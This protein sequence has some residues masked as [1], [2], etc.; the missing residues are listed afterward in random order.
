MATSTRGSSTA[1]LPCGDERL[2]SIDVD[3]TDFPHL[4]ATRVLEFRAVEVVGGQ[5]SGTS[6]AEFLMRV[7]RSTSPSRIASMSVLVLALTCI[8][9]GITQS[10]LGWF[11]GAA[12]NCNGLRYPVLGSN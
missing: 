11:P 10:Q 1:T 2:V 12:A 8:V 3:S 9:I 7:G 5:R 4:P 6:W